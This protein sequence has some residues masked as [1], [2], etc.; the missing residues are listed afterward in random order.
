MSKVNKLYKICERSLFKFYDLY[1]SPQQ[2]FEWFSTTKPHKYIKINRCSGIK[3]KL[4]IKKDY[5]YFF[6]INTFFMFFF[7]CVVC[8]Y[9]ANK[10]LFIQYDDDHMNITIIRQMY[11]LWQ[12]KRKNKYE[13]NIVTKMCGWC[14]CL[15]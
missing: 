15:F 4:N 10:F 8:A 6:F 14:F 3:N 7:V 9:S 13:L 11:V 1:T 12:V 5:P 2:Y